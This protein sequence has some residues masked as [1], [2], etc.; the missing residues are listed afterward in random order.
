M[1]LL[2]AYQ[3]GFATNGA[4]PATYDLIWAFARK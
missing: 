1:A 3:A 2:A 4:I